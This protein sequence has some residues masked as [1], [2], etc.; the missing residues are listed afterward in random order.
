[1]KVE[2]AQAASY[3]RDVLASCAEGSYLTRTVLVEPGIK[4]AGRDVRACVYIVV[5]FRP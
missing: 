1:M 5:K 4:E 3:P 2:N